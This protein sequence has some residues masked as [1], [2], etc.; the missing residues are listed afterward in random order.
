[1]IYFTF[2]K[3][4]N[5]CHLQPASWPLMPRS[6]G[7][8]ILGEFP[9]Q[10]FAT[11]KIKLCQF[12]SEI[13]ISYPQAKGY[14]DG[15]KYAPIKKKIK[16]MISKLPHFSDVWKISWMIISI[17]LWKEPTLITVRLCWLDEVLISGRWRTTILKAL[18]N[19]IKFNLI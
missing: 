1:M 9:N 4:F 12:G 3:L 11:N 8:F 14:S 6:K 13:E 10:H 19:Q 2:W 15:K 17:T 16:H 18:K 7:D 5:I